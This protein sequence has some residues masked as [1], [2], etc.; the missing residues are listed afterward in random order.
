MFNGLNMFMIG[1]TELSTWTIRL[2]VPNVALPFIVSPV[3]VMLSAA[4]TPETKINADKTNKQTA[5]FFIKQTVK[6]PI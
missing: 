4:R 5:N 1:G 2:K 3:M 6:K